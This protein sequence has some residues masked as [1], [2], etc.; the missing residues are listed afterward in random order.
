MLK[1]HLKKH[2][3][4]YVVG[5][6]SLT[7]AVI[8]VLIMRGKNAAV[9]SAPENSTEFN[10]HPFQK[11]SHAALVE[12]T[13]CPKGSVDSF[14]FFSGNTTH[15]DNSPITNVVNV[16][17]RN[18]RGH[19]GY[20]IKCLETNELFDSQRT[21]AEEFNGSATMLSEHLRWRLGDFKGYH[22]ERVGISI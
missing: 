12:G 5:S 4:V 11:E 1:E 18:G 10:V 7:I 16:L 14:S 22:F 8:T 21:V 19:P 2:K 13:D 3:E 6:L 9:Q 17:E 20:I 15:G